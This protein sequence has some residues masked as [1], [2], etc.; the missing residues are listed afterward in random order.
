MSQ[1]RL[2]YLSCLFFLFACGQDQANGPTQHNSSDEFTISEGDSVVATVNSIPITRKRIEILSRETGTAPAEVLQRLINFELLA[3]ES[4][5]RGLGRSRHIRA[6]ERKAMVQQFLSEEFEGNRRP[7][8]VPEFVLRAAYKQNKALFVRPNLRTVAYIL[9]EA[10]EK[11][12]S[13][14]KRRQAFALAREIHHKVRG[15]KTTEE[16]LDI[17][18]SY[19]GKG[20]FKVNALKLPKSVHKRALLVQP[21]IDAAM[22]LDRPG[23]I[24]PPFESQYGA[25]IV[26]LIKLEKAINQSFDEVS[27][28]VRGKV[29]G[30]WLRQEFFVMAEKLRSETTVQGYVGQR[31]RVER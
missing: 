28:Q 21:F 14:T 5:R 19:Q 1:V 26:Y 31:R 20:G 9:V 23:Q 11:T 2:T 7:E 8:D 22:K 15:A 16:F 18:K 27:D 6:I 4:K 17:G 12:S 3:A 30:S 25:H 13:S 10:E 24:S 29:H